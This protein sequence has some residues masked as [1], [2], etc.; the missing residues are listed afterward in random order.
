MILS[1]RRALQ[2]AAG[3]VA[4]PAVLR[5]AHGQS[6]PSRPVTVIVG[7]APGGAPDVLARL[8]AQSLQE[9]LGQTFIVENR[10]GGSGN[11]ATEAVARAAPDG[12]TLLLCISGNAINATRSTTISSSISSTTLRRS[13]AWPADRT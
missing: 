12:H 2:V 10:Q 9:Q 3:A 1:R 7:F 11:I 4:L 8:L 13:Q 5:R 6:Y